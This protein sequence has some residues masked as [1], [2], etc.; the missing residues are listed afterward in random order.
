MW[1]LRNRSNPFVGAALSMH[2]GWARVARDLGEESPSDARF[3]LNE[4]QFMLVESAILREDW[5]R[6]VQSVRD[7][8]GDNKRPQV[9]IEKFSPGEHYYVGRTK[10][11]SEVAAVKYAN[12]MG[13]RVLPGIKVTSMNDLLLSARYRL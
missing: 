12:D 3:G 13:Y 11:A 2:L 9:Q 7:F 4:L 1:S 5:K 10:F 8:R 6:A